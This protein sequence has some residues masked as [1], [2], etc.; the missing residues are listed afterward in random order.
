MEHFKLDPRDLFFILKEQLSYGEVCRL[1]RYADL[2]E[3]ALDLVVKEA[4]R[5]ARQ[6]VAPLNPIGEARGVR[7]EDG[8]VFCPPEFKAAFARFGQQGW[9]AAARDTVYGGQG[10]PHMLRIV[11]NDVMYGACQSFNMAPS[12]THGAGHLIERF[13]A[14]ELARRFVPRMYNGTWS[15]TMCLTETE[16]G[17]NLGAVQT[18][19]EPVGAQ[20]RIQGSKI[21]I[22][23]GD[24]DIAENIIHLLLAR[25]RGAPEG[26][27]GLSLFVVPKYRVNPDGSLGAFNDVV[28]TGLESKLGLRASPT[29]S[30]R[31]GDRNG[32]LGFLCGQENRGL[33][34]MFQM[35]NSARINTAVSGMSL[36]GTAYQNALEY[37]KNR[38]Q[39][40]DA[41]AREPGQ[42]PIIAH[43][44]V[45]RMLLWM[46]AAVDGMR[47]LI[48]TAAF[49]EDQAK[50]LPEGRVKDRYRNL[51]DFVTP[52]LKATCSDLGF[53]VCETAIQCLGG[54]GYCRDYPL[55]QYLRDVK[56][57][58]LYEGTNGIQALDLMGR[59][60]LIRDGA[61][62]AAYQET[63]AGFCSSHRKDPGL[64]GRIQALEGVLQRLW[65]VSGVML[66]T[67]AEDPLQWAA[68]TASM[69]RAFGEVSLI[70]RLLDM[71]LVAN[72]ALR[73]AKGRPL[74]F[75]RG[76]VAQAV[77]FT[78]ITLPHTLAT[79]E[80][81]P[82]AGREVVNLPTA[83]F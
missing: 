21:F 31:F 78:D 9:T 71:G 4:I 56:I 30:L 50:E 3:A 77:Y 46:K 29:A 79:L 63:L 37:A 81:C 20:F 10:L 83:S 32:C 11:I 40:R 12:L 73:H 15:G 62:F 39:G 7:L 69:L 43:P 70:W 67:R 49:W 60:M 42:V 22:S 66:R 53:R 41:A 76:K 65:E 80:S 23:W 82:G 55:E 14:P 24:H 6:V 8:R 17:S 38:V 5:F 35:M 44:D 34:Q 72:K 18:A 68:S 13:A 54:Y 27:H 57:L 64:G 19:A 33:A 2:N 36:A 26:V 45:L 59:K 51:L 48:Y 61:C 74:H 25:I 52:I 1:E 28:C 47:S 75:Y 58:S 16:A